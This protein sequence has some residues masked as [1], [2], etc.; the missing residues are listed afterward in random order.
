MRV[1]EIA[2]KQVYFLRHIS[3][4]GS[5]LDSLAR[6]N[7]DAIHHY[8]T[9]MINKLLGKWSIAN[10]KT[11][12]DRSVERVE[13]KIHIEAAGEFS[14]LHAAPQSFVYFL[15]AGAHDT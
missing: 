3:K 5:R 12:V 10:K 13:Q 8:S 4:A 7:H 11:K 6:R 14:T 15:P 9:K 1:A 2:L